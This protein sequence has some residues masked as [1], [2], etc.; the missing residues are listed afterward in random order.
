MFSVMVVEDDAVARRLTCQVLRR[1]GYE[2][3][4]ASDG[5]EALSL[6]DRYHVDLF[7]LDIMMPGMDGFEFI[8]TVRGSRF[9]TPILMTT[10]KGSLSDKREAFRAGADDYMVKPIEEEEL[11][12]RVSAL[13]RRAKI[14]TERRLTVGRSTL[15]Y[16]AFSVTEEGAPEQILPQKEFLLL[17]QLLSYPGKIFTRRQLMDELWGMESETDERTVDVHIKRLRDRFAGNRDFEI[18]TIR[19][20]GYRANP[21][22]EEKK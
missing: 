4:P 11:L 18:V 19:G 17:F 22:G 9:E 13:L 12:L 10:A 5:N 2:P 1:G 3:I 6:M 7:I 16:D 21:T 14:A 8:R 20:L 15:N